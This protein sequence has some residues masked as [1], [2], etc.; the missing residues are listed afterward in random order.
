MMDTLSSK[1]G[2]DRLE[3]INSMILTLNTLTRSVHGWRNWIQNLPLM[4]KFT[5]DEL[6]EMEEGLRKRVRTFIEHDIEVTK[7][8]K[9][10]FPNLIL[11]KK[12][13]TKREDTKSMYV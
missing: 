9:D 13:R 11:Q 10:K 7:Q 4:S 5:E 12:R 8:H 2:K 3:L 1:K 6:K